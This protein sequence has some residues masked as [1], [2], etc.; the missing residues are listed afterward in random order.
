M[1][2]LTV[3]D[4]KEELIGAY[5]PDIG[6]FLDWEDIPGD[7]AEAEAAAILEHA[8]KDVEK[9][10]LEAN[11]L[12]VTQDLPEWEQ[13]TGQTESRLARSGTVAQRRAQI[14]SRLRERGATTVDM[15][16]RVVQPFL[17]YADPSQIVVSEASRAELRAKHTRHNVI[18][19]ILNA[20]PKSVAWKVRDDAKVSKAGA[21]VDLTMHIPNLA[22]LVVQLSGPDGIPHT[23]IGPGVG[24][25][26]GTGVRLYFPACAG[27][28]IYGTWGILISLTNGDSGGLTEAELFVEGLGRDFKGNDGLGA[29]KFQWG[30]IVEDAKLGA[31]F[32]L[33]GAFSSIKRIN[34]ATRAGHIIRRS[35]GIGKLPPGQFAALPD[36]PNTI[37]DECIPGV[38]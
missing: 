33:R 1:S 11:P 13:V 9:L 12:T 5:P 14:I 3:A 18:P 10:R 25:V 32:D 31:G 28:N 36:D 23:I 27:E 29:A 8:I 26:A 2:E 19:Q 34:Y 16:R 21:Q 17:N 7:I 38:P 22:H 4:V 20:A 37:P 6:D 30:V 24:G 15:I 35:N